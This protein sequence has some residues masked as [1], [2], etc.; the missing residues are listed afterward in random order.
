MFSPQDS[1]ERTTRINT[2]DRA[3]MWHPAPF[4]SDDARALDPPGCAG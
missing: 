2:L 4:Y 1:Y 3:C